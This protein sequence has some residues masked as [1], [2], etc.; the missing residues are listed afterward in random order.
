VQRAGADQREVGDQRA[1]LGDVLDA[2]EQV[3]VGRV[4]LRDDRRAVIVLVIDQR[5][6]LVAAQPLAAVVVLVQR[7]AQHLGDAV[8]G[9]GGEARGLLDDVARDVGQV[10]Q[11]VGL[12]EVRGRDAIEHA[13][14]DA[15]GD[16][17]LERELRGGVGVGPLVGLGEHRRQLVADLLQ[18]RAQRRLLLGRQSLE[19]VGLDH[20]PLLHRRHDD[21]AVGADDADPPRPRA[22]LQRLER[23]ALALLGLADQRVLAAAVL[24]AVER[25]H[26]RGGQLADRPRHVGA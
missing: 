17:A 1:Q 22:L 5:V 15:L 16:L 9:L 11:H 12:I 25:R 21:A 24:V 13:A 6:D 3:G 8:V 18:R 7:L 2:P 26:H 14:G 4:L 10:G 19:L 23:G 20:L